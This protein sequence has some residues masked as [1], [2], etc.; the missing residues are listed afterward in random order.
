MGQNCQWTM[1]CASGRRL[2]QWCMWA[3][4]MWMATG[5]SLWAQSGAVKQASASKVSA[6]L[7]TCPNCNQDQSAGGHRSAAPVP[8]PAEHFSNTPIALDETSSRSQEVME[9]ACNCG[10]VSGCSDCRQTGC[11]NGCCTDGGCDCGG[12]AACRGDDECCSVG[13][14]IC[15]DGWPP[16]PL[17]RLLCRLSVRAEV[18]LFWRKGH[19]TPPLVSTGPSAAAAD[20]NILQQGDFGQ[21]ANAG[22]RITLS[23]WLDPCQNHGIQFRFWNAGTR[24]DNH[25]FDSDS[26]PI[27]ARPFRNTSVSGSPANDT[28]VIAATGD[29]TGSIA[30][31]GWSELYGLDVNL[32]R[33]LYAD[34]FTRLDWTY[35]YQYFTLGERLRIDSQTTLIRDIPPLQTG[36]TIGVMDHFQTQ[37]RLHGTTSGFMCTRRIACF[38]LESM[39]RLGM[40]NLNRELSVRGSTTTTSGNT[41]NTEQ[42]GLLARETNRR[43]IID[44]TFVISPEVGVNLA[45]ALSP[46]VDF[47]VGYNYLMVPKVYQASGLIDRDLTVNL[48]DPLTGSLDPSLRLSPTRY[49]VRS[50]GLGLQLRY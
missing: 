45:W 4:L 14:R 3:I 24:N 2:R 35:G 36:T 22:F 9:D 49:W 11:R 50:L 7:A 6:R 31:R 28:Q 5:T 8:V 12:R 27:L 34:R 21:D 41:T 46:M 1:C 25:L 33:L 13:P 44:N 38:Q 42:Q 29:S 23:T 43:T 48:S 30:V 15:G 18:P 16:G 10:C 37:N 32:K 39:F 26:T 40:G 20:T 17:A 47:T 19:D